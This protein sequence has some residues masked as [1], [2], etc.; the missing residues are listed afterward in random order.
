M[1]VYTSANTEQRS[2][3]IKELRSALSKDTSN[4]ELRRLITSM[5]W[6]ANSGRQKKVHNTETITNWDVEYQKLGILPTRVSF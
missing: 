3:T 4:S 6:L 1:S 2:N 5:L